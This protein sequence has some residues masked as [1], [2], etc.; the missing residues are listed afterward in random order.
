VPSSFTMVHQQLTRPRQHRWAF[1]QPKS[2]ISK[3]YAFASIVDVSCFHGQQATYSRRPWM[4][5]VSTI[6]KLR[7][8]SR[9]ECTAVVRHRGATYSPA[10]LPKRAVKRQSLRIREGLAWKQLA[11][12]RGPGHSTFGLSTRGQQALL[13][14]TAYHATPPATSI[15]ALGTAHAAP[16]GQSDVFSCCR[17]VH[18]IP[19]SRQLPAR[20][21][22]PAGAL[23]SRRSG[24]T[25]QASVRTAAGS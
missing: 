14:T 12:R 4:R 23:Y 11:S 18:P 7:I 17:A 3:H 15:C 25:V 9:C 5:P 21:D 20:A 1:R 19:R 22:G 10:P 8:R 2:G 16:A 6:K 13:P 24:H